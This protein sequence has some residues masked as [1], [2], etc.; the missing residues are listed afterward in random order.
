MNECF[1]VGDYALNYIYT[2]ANTNEIFKSCSHNLDLC[3]KMGMYSSS[4]DT[5][6]HF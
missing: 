6:L 5:L 3:F 4:T 1:I 2:V